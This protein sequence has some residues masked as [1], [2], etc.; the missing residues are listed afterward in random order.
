MHSHFTHGQWCLSG[1]PW[2]G[3][4]LDLPRSTGF[5][6][7]ASTQNNQCGPTAGPDSWESPSTQE[8]TNFRPGSFH[9]VCDFLSSRQHIKQHSDYSLRSC[10]I[11]SFYNLHFHCMVLVLAQQPSAP[12]PFA[13]FIQWCFILIHAHQ[14]VDGNLF[15]LIELRKLP[16][17]YL[18][19]SAAGD[20][21]SV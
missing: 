16:S 9:I 18:S 2:V 10:L 5:T 17:I 11:S 14:Q 13:V 1:S 4:V 15:C 19:N 3:S 6:S 8:Q 12:P 20:S 7:A 21:A